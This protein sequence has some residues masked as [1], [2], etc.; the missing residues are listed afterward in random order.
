MR[1]HTVIESPIGALTLVATTGTLSGLY[2]QEHRHQ[3]DVSTFGERRAAGFEEAVEQLGEYFAGQRRWFSVPTSLAGGDFQSR[4]WHA[5]ATIP[6][7][8]TTTYG[9]IAAALGHPG[10]A[11]AVGTAVG[12]NP[13]SVVVPCH[14][15]VGS[16]GNLTGFAGGLGRKRFLLDL[17]RPPQVPAQLFVP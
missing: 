6:F 10:A 7:G 12:R 16:N 5:L 8:E 11:R 14:R 15:V 4:V 2:M 1:T 9:R 17:E 13:I 3:P